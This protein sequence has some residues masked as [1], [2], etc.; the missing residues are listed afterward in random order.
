MPDAPDAW[1]HPV[2]PDAPNYRVLRDTEQTT[3]G[4]SA[5]SAGGKSARHVR[6]EPLPM[7]CH[8]PSVVLRKRGS[9]IFSNAK[10]SQTPGSVA[11]RALRAG[12][13][14]KSGSGIFSNAK[15]SLTP[16]PPGV[17]RR[18]GSGQGMPCPYRPAKRAEAD[19]C[20]AAAG[21]KTGPELSALLLRRW[22]VSRL[23]ACR[24]QFQPDFVP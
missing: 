16:F 11:V 18:S 19:R 5:G 3:A 15:S 2:A 8:G 1:A 21:S 12:G 4:V 9:G 17:E 13:L 22:G 23:L 20:C 7:S 6:G 14:R 10:S 24:D